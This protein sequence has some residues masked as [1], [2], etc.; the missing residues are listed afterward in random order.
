MKINYILQQYLNNN[1]SLSIIKPV[2]KHAQKIEE[3]E[4]QLL[5]TINSYYIKDIDKAKIELCSFKE[6]AK[7]QA[8]QTINSYEDILIKYNHYLN[9]E[10]FNKN[11]YE[12]YD[13]L[14]KKVL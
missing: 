14:N 7:K 10:K 11:I 12:I 5:D 3:Y 1:K 6:L 13:I 2:L 9:I 8:R 4:L